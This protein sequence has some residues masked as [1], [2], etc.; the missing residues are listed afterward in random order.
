VESTTHCVK[1]TLGGVSVRVINKKGKSPARGH[2]PSEL[3]SESTP[4]RRTKNNDFLLIQ[5]NGLRSFN[6]FGCGRPLQNKRRVTM[7]ERYHLVSFGG[8]GNRPFH[9]I[10]TT[11]GPSAP[12][13]SLRPTTHKPRTSHGKNPRAALERLEHST[14]RA[15]FTRTV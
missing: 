9:R 10:T 1:C 4:Q 7:S 3:T 11:E 6:L 8:V 2:P 12:V 5:V 15:H 14:Q 13:S